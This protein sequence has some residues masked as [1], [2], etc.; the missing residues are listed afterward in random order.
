MGEWEEVE[1]GGLVVLVADLRKKGEEG[2][3]L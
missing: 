1:Q 2:P 3:F